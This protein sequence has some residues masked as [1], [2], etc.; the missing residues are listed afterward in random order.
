ALVLGDAWERA[1]ADFQWKPIAVPSFS[2]WYFSV[3]DGEQTRC[4]GVMVQPAALCSWTWNR[5]SITLLAD[6][7]NACLDTLFGGRELTLAT[8]V[9]YADIGDPWDVIHAFCKKMC[10]HPVLPQEPVIGGD[11]WYAYY[12]DNSYDRILRHTKK[13]AEC[14]QGLKGRPVQTVDAGWQLCHNW[15]PGEEYIGG[16]YRYANSK[17][18]DMRKMAD[19]IRNLGVKPG[20]WIRPLETVEYVSKEAYTLRKREIKYLDPTHPEAQE[21]LD[22]DIQQFLDWGFESIKWDFLVVDIFRNYAPAMNQSVVEGDWGFHDRTR[23]SAEIC[24]DYYR[25]T[26][27]IAKG[28]FI[29]T[30]NTFSH[31][32][33]GCF[34]CYRI[35]DDTSGS[36]WSRT[37]KYGVNA[38]A[39][40]GM[41]HGA[42]YAG[43]ADCCGITTKI[44]WKRNRE[45]LHLLKYSGTPLFVSIQDEAYTNEV[46]DEITSAFALASGRHPTARALDWDETLTPRRW[47]TFDGV[48]EFNWD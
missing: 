15:Y 2:P 39:F 6:V 13:L 3:R 29:N 7:R 5:T 25:R 26:A 19:A 32:S 23:T 30:C 1:Y 34:P 42:F 47:Q 38:L 8:L 4:F 40:R 21:I 33:A 45:W 14:T 46:R 10:P 12:S 44:P 20:L 18:G 27:K 48:K 35:G 11:D 41:Q 43:D 24:R 16:P 9:S 17:F 37:V 36:D 31:L 22:G 28:A